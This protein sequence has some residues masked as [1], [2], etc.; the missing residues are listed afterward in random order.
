MCSSAPTEASAESEGIGAPLTVKLEPGS[1]W[2]AALSAGLSTQSC[3]QARRARRISGIPATAVISAKR[4][5]SSL[6]VSVAFM[7]LKFSPRPPPLR[8]VSL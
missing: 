3:A 2:K 8:S 6:R 4:A 1:A 5:P 7:A